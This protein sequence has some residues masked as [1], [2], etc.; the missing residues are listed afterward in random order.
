MPAVPLLRLAYGS[1]TKQDG[2]TLGNFNEQI[3]GVWRERGHPCGLLRSAERAREHA[4]DPEPQAP[5]RTPDRASVGAT[6]RVEVS[7]SA[8]VRE[9]DGILVRLRE[10]RRRVPDDEHEPA[11]LQRARERRIGA[12][13]GAGS[14][15]RKCRGGYDGDQAARGAS[16][17]H[18]GTGSHAAM[19]PRRAWRRVTLWKPVRW[20]SPP[21][22]D[23]RP[24]GLGRTRTAGSGSRA[25]APCPS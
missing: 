6:L 1:A 19:R 3:R 25:R 11:S 15:A 4:P 7:L 12:R 21:A 18:R 20:R 16:K 5:N 13:R 22:Q 2:K 17:H 9:D 10:V 23:R 8:A 24:I 14:A